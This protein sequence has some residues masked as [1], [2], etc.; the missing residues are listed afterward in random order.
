LTSKFDMNEE[1]IGVALEYSG[2][3]PTVLAVARGV[4]YEHLIRIAQE[5]N[6]TIYENPDLAQTL[7]AIPW[8]TEI[9]ADLFRAV[10]EVLA[11][12]YRVNAT[13]KKKLD[14]RGIL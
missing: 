14:G 11:Y 7:S 2:D 13:F 8:G 4:L 6:I 12:C 9:P 10:S 1:K 3:I 5:H